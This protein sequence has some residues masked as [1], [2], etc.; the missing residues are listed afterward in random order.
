MG[1]FLC[2]ELYSTKESQTIQNCIVEYR[3][4]HGCYLLYS[5][6]RSKCIRPTNPVLL[7][8]H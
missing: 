4:T 5:S 2:L 8:L 3:T 7:A 1:A 6:L